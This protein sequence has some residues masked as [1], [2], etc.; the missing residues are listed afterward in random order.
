MRRLFIVSLAVLLL[1]GCQPTPEKAAVVQKDS[2]R[3]I[4]NAQK[5]AKESANKGPYRDLSGQYGIPASYQFRMQGANGKLNVKADARTVVPDRD[6]MPI[7]RVKAAE[8]TQE[9]VDALWSALCGGA[10]MRIRSG[11]ETKDRIRSR[12]VN[13]KKYI[14]EIA[15]DPKQSDELELQK[16]ILADVEKQ[17][18]TAPDT[19]DEGHSDGKLMQMSDRLGKTFYTGIDAYERDDKGLDGEGR[20]FQ[21]KNDATPTVLFIDNRDPAAGT[22]FGSSAS[23]PVTTDTDIGVD[24]LPK[25]GLTPREARQKV[26]DILDRAKTGMVA[27]SIYLLDDGK[28]G[29]AEQYAYRIYCVRSVDGLPCS[30]I[31]G[32]SHP[33]EDAMASFWVYE[34]LECMVDRTGVFSFMWSDPIEVSETVNEDAKL[35]PFSEI[36]EIFE[37]M[38]RMKYEPQ[39]EQSELDFEINRVT[40]CLHRIVEKNSNASGLLV[41]AWNFY[42]KLKVNESGEEYEKFEM[43]GKSF[44][45]INAVDGSVIDCSLGY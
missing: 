9:Q 32:A 34:E 12:I 43:L 18:E 7:Y 21:V 40:L 36:R 44:M 33:K 17:L 42:G 27:D 24:I 5:N 2:D 19:V 13:I 10:E 26:Q 16:G 38:M 3:L 30:Y 8:F 4:E 39:A 31:S 14:V 35:K 15:G 1:S 6:R 28:K 29:E 23:V 22:S 25:V 41:P 11:Q 45:T 37:K 20:I